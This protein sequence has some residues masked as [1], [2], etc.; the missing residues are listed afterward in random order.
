M[1]KLQFKLTKLNKNGY[2]YGYGYGYGH[3]Y[4]Y[5]YG[6]GYGYGYGYIYI[7][8]I[9]NYYLIIEK[10]LIL[11]LRIHWFKILYV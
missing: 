4:G 3:G 2:G 5:G 1:T 10:I 11:N 9:K 8:F 7:L 6:C